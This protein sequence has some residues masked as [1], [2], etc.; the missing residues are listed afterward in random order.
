MLGFPSYM[1]TSTGNIAQFLNNYALKLPQF[2][3][4]LQ[5]PMSE[6][7]TVTYGAAIYNWFEN[8]YL[9]QLRAA[10]KAGTEARDAFGDTH[11]NPTPFNPNVAQ[12]TPAPIAPQSVTLSNGFVGFVD[13]QVKRIKL[14]QAYKSNPQIGIELGINTTTP[15]V[16]TPL[17][18]SIESV[19]AQA[20]FHMEIRAKRLGAKTVLFY[21]MK[22]AAAPEL[23]GALAS[24]TFVDERPPTV[25]GQSELRFYAAR[26]GDVQGKPLPNSV[27]SDVVSLPTHP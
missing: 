1:G 24:A 15:A 3:S 5:M 27:M 26:Y 13:N 12:F 25:A 14:S 22:D 11:D 8:V 2:A 21:D 10:S 20:G 23:L 17:K 4:E 6:V 16:V 19:S 7:D 9:P 18:A